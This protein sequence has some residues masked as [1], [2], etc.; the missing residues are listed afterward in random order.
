[1]K[2]DNTLALNHKKQVGES[3]LPAIKNLTQIL[4]SSVGLYSV[5][6]RQP[7][8]KATETAMLA[9]NGKVAARC[10]HCYLR[11]KYLNEG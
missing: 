8:S 1:M 2:N 11:K 5:K 3:Y 4:N 6:H 9:Q 7:Q 10:K